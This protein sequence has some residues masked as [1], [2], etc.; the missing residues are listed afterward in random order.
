[1]KLSTLFFSVLFLHIGLLKGQVQNITLKG[2]LSFD[3]KA[4]DIWGYTAPDGTEYALVGLRSGV[5][6]V[7]LAD[8]A[9]PTEVA[10]IEGEE[11]IWRDLRTRGH[12]CYV[13]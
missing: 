11:S 8:P 10:F 12:Y 5:S 2:H 13:V 4:N 1:M 9:N 6:I 7:S 3:S